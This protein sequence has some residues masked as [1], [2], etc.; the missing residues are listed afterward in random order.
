MSYMKFMD[1]YDPTASKD[2]NNDLSVAEKVIQD[3]CNISFALDASRD[4]PSMKKWLISKVSVLLL[5]SKKEASSLLYS[6]VTEGV[7]SLIEKS[8]EFPTAEIEGSVERKKKQTSIRPVI[9][10]Q[11][12]DDSGFQQLAFLAFKDAVGISKFDLVTLEKHV[13]YSLTK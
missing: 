12:D 1:Q 13:V 8:L 9:V 2:M 5:D 11:N 4:V 6:S 7:W 3:A 10:E